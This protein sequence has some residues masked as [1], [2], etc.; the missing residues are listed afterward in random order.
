M[1]KN[2]AN[3]FWQ[4]K[5]CAS[6]WKF[7]ILFKARIK[8]KKIHRGLEFNQS[9]YLKPNTEFST[10]TRREVERNGYSDRKVL[11]KLMNNIEYGKTMENWRNKID[12]WLINKEKDYLK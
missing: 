1:S 12:A 10:P 8:V 3:F 4:R 7:T 9:H 5:V 11:H 2:G 6:F